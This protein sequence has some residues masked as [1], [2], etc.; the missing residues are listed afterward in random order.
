MKHLTLG[1][2][3][4]LTILVIALLVALIVYLSKPTLLALA[5]AYVIS[6]PVSPDLWDIA[7]QKTG[8]RNDARRFRAASLS[9]LK[10]AARGWDHAIAQIKVFSHSCSRIL[11]THPLCLYMRLKP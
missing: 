10:T 9:I 7:P 11:C 6:G 1:K 4:H 3:S 2:K 8:R 5:V